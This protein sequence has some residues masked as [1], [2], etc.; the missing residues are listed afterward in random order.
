M[1]K[2][3]ENREVAFLD[4]TVY[5]GEQRKV[6]CTYCQK[7]KKQEKCEKYHRV[8]Y[9]KALSIYKQLALL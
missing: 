1:E 8:Y 4:M 7:P 6:S 5:I 3:N 2:M 9:P